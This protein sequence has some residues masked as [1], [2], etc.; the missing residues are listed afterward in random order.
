MTSIPTNTFYGCSSLKDVV[1]PVS[2]TSFSSGA[3][4]NATSSLA[5]VYYKGTNSQWNS[6]S[7]SG[8]SS[9]P[10][11]TKVY[12]YTEIEPTGSGRYWHYVDGVPTVW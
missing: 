5:H 12:Y 4:S 2:V 7:F 11:T 3:F 9:R 1:I 8:S 6:I 10:T